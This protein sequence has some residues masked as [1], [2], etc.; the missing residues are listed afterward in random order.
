MRTGKKISLLL[1]MLLC[2]ISLLM[3]M[4]FGGGADRLYANISFFTA[5]A[6]LVVFALFVLREIN[7][8][9][10]LYNTLLMREQLLEVTLNS[11]GEGVITTDVAGKITALNPSAELLTGWK[12]AEALGKP[13]TAVYAVINEETGQPF[14]NIV[15]RILKNGREIAFENNTILHKKDGAEIIISNNGSPLTT[16]DG[17]MLGAVLIFRDITYK[18]E[19]EEKLEQLVAERT[20]ELTS[21]NSELEAFTYSVS[22]D[23]RAPLRAVISYARIFEEDYMQLLDAGGKRQLLTIRQSA[24]KMSHLIDDLLSFS[25]VGKL[26]LQKKAIDMSALTAEVLAELTQGTMHTA[27]I[28]IQPLPQ[29]VADTTLIKSVMMNLLGN[30]IKY[31]SKKEQA[32]ITVSAQQTEQELVFSVADNGAGFDMRY[33]N[34]LFGVFQRLHTEDEFIG[35]GV[36]LA[37]ANRIITRHEGKMWAEAEVEKGATFYFSLP[38]ASHYQAPEN[39]PG[40]LTSAI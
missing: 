36:G 27:Q 18:K 12:K 5:F 33:A 21:A 10:K 15:S 35:T 23:L 29:I 28:N 16:A 31:S 6:G 1:V 24:E 34:K 11:L 4:R 37:I 13:L 30:A 14:E 19:A 39:V 8:S 3:A 7:S 17:Q 40:L 38:L 22:H 20:A 32:Q 26:S 25:R 9:D 2:I